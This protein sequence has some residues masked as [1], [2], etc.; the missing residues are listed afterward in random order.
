MASMMKINFDFSKLSTQKQ[1][2]STYELEGD[3][4]HI[5]VKSITSNVIFKSTEESAGKIECTSPEKLVHTVKV[6]NGELV[7]TEKDSRKWYEHIGFFFGKSV[8]TVYIPVYQYSNLT[9]TSNTGNI[10]LPKDFSFEKADLK[11]DTGNIVC[12]SPSISILNASTHTGNITVNNTDT[13]SIYLSTDTGEIKVASLKAENTLSCKNNTGNVT[14]T[15]VNTKSLT[16]ETDTGNVILTSF[17]AEEEI[18]VSTDTGNIVLKQT[19]AKTLDLETDTGNVTGTLCSEKIF[20][21]KSDTGSIKVPYSDKGGICKI[22][23]DTGDIRITI[24]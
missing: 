23:T 5:N 16:A 18:K 13:S 21:T 10:D 11:S 19:D 14:L 2:T 24:E 4:S 3:F 17:I 7:V 6:E 15:N 9:V 22:T 1:V 8:I 20:V 12:S